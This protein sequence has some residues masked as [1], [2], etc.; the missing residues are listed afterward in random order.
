MVSCGAAASGLHTVYG[1]LFWVSIGIGV[2]SSSG[3]LA[4]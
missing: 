2:E 3:R 1:D 4:T